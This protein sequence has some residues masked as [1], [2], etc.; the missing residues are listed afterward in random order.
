MAHEHAA[1][2][3]KLGLAYT[4]ALITAV[5]SMPACDKVEHAYDCNQICDRYQECLNSDYDTD[6]CASRCRDKADDTDYGNHA[7]DCQACID[8]KSCVNATFSCASECAGIVP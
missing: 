4:I 8:D 6:A 5:A 2:M 7:E 3:F 1:A